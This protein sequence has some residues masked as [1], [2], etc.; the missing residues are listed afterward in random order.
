[1]VWRVAQAKQ[2]RSGKVL[3]LARG[4]GQYGVLRS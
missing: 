3:E 2:G 1:A 4:A